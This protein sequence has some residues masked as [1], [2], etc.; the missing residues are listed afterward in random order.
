MKL[1]IGKWALGVRWHETEHEPDGVCWFYV[2]NWLWPEHRFWGYRTD[3]YYQ[4][5]YSFGFWFF[6]L[7]WSW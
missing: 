4:P 3:Y 2:F 6:N 1:D 7:C 5:L